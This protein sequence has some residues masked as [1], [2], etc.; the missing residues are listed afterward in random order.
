MQNINFALTLIWFGQHKNRSSV[1]RNI[2]L[3][4]MKCICEMPFLQIYILLPNVGALQ[5]QIGISF[6]F[7]ILFWTIMLENEHQTYGFA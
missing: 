3:E 1:K 7:S 4:W 5:M 6:N 2:A